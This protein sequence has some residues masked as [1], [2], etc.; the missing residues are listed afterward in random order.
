[1]TEPQHIIAC[2]ACDLL[3]ER[4]SL[5]LGR[6]AHCPRCRQHLYGR[7]A[8]RPSQLMALTLTGFLLL[9]SAFLEPLLYMRLG[10]VDTE[11]NVLRGIAM[12]FQDGEP[13]VA[14]LVLWCAVLA[15]VGLL[16]GIFALASGLA[17]RWHILPITLRAVETFRHWAM[18]EVYLVSFLVALFKLVDIAETRLGG[19]LLSLGILMLLNLTLLILFD[20]SPYWEKV[21]CQGARDA[22]HP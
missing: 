18:L 1:M 5:P 21:P 19:G 8:F 12:L 13:W 20:P 4:Q 17:K 11:A 10:G 15:P 2:P 9:P 3:I 7:Y 16:S 22:E 14:G 6:H